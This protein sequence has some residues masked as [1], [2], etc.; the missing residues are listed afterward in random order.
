MLY[1]NKNLLKKAGFSKPHPRPGRSSKHSAAPSSSKRR[2]PSWAMDDRRLDDR[3]DDLLLRRRAALA[4]PEETLFDS[5]ASV[6]TFEL[7]DRLFKAESPIRSRAT[8]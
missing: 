3:W 4:G 8:T 2:S 5:P 7:L 1:Y 6:K